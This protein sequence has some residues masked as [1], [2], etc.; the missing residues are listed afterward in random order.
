MKHPHSMK[1][2][3]Y[4][5]R[6]GYGNVQKRRDISAWQLL[7]LLERKDGQATR[8]SDGQ[9]SCRCH[10]YLDKEL[11]AKVSIPPRPKDLDLL[12]PS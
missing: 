1:G 12:E 10:D 7:S 2:W 11:R 9:C 8:Y 4:L 5:E 3:G 6:L